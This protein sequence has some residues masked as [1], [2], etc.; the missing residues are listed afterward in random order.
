M[1]T[2]ITPYS[3]NAELTAANGLVVTD[4]GKWLYSQS[5]YNDR[6]T[7]GLSLGFPNALGP[8]DFYYGP[9]Q[10][11]AVPTQTGGVLSL[12]ATNW[13]IAEIGNELTAYTDPTTGITYPASQCRIQ[14]RGQ[15]QVIRQQNSNSFNG[16]GV[17]YGGTTQTD[18]GD[19]NYWGTWITGF[20]TYVIQ[21]AAVTGG[22][23]D[24][25]SSHEFFAT[26]T[27]LATTDN[28]N[29][30]FQSNTITRPT[31]VYSYTKSWQIAP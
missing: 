15:W 19:R 28:S 1:P 7:F 13:T 10:S 17:D 26:M 25:F 6:A 31:W 30:E 2:F 24:T 9:N 29:K 16:Q 8:S 14:V 3:G 20:A 18:L 11:G 21:G 12:S 27:E 23:Q 22:A 5:G 4:Q